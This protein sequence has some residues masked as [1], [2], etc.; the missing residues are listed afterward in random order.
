M[1]FACFGS[2]WCEKRG[3]PWP[4]YGPF[5]RPRLDLQRDCRGLTGN[6]LM[7]RKLVIRICLLID[8]V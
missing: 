4:V 7:Q 8:L 3:V 1:R 2:V 5:L 6:R